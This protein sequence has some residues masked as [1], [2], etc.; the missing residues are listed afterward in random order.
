MPA[1]KTAD[2]RTNEEI[3]KNMKHMVSLLNKQVG[4]TA[5]LKKEQKERKDL[6]AQEKLLQAK[7]AEQLDE[8]KKNLTSQEVNISSMKSF[9]GNEATKYFKLTEESQLT[10]GGLATS[11][12]EGVKDWFNAA[13]KQNNMLGKTLR[14]GASLWKAAH[15]HIIDNV[16]KLWGAVT[17]QINEVLGEL[18][19]VLNWVKDSFVSVFKF[20][21][22]SFMGFFKRVPPAD[23]KRNKLLQAIVGYMRRGEKRDLLQDTGDGKDG[24]GI[25]AALAL[26]AAGVLGAFLGKL[27]L[28][29]KVLAKAFQ[30]DKVFGAIGRFLGKFKIIKKLLKWIKKPLDAMGKI[31]KGAKAVSPFFRTALQ[32]FKWGFTKLAWPLQIIMSVFDFIDGFVKTEGN[33]ADK[34]IGGVKNA[35]T[36]FIELP[37]KLIGWIVEKVLGLFGVEVTGVADKIMGI[38]QKWWDILLSVFRPIIG[39]FE[40][41]FS[42][43]GS[44]MDKIKG[45]FKGFMGGIEGM[46][47]V[48][49]PIIEFLKPITDWIK[50]VFDDWLNGMKIMLEALQPFID[51]ITGIVDSVLNF[52]GDDDEEEID[53]ASKKTKG[54]AWNPMN[55]FGDEEQPAT[56]DP[57]V[58]IPKPKSELNTVLDAQA[59][60]DAELNQQQIEANQKALEKQTKEQIDAQ[61][62]IADETTEA[63][64]MAMG[65]NA[66]GGA[67]AAPENPLQDE[68][69]IYS[70]IGSN[71]NY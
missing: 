51:K 66:Q 67:A 25:I 37:V 42:T 71:N 31:F 33:L 7:Y 24:W 19:G 35:F 16:K 10:W 1:A 21:K 64:A 61:K 52:F 12:K 55:W 70:F 69:D 34:I 8:E 20:M 38:F 18:G 59:K 62:K 14:L 54:S 11:V 68:V 47:K 48:F 5:E 44:F 63:T 49:E 13:Q 32:V 58:N 41:F 39:L 45:A 40:G 23:R 27:L 29:F 60:R 3:S 57:N 43:E 22:D 30:L 50:K 26:V 56:P 53:E 28:P 6:L 17:G 15:T 46:L 65:G 36:K 4:N 2:A 9:I